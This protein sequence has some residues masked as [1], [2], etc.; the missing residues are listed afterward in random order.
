MKKQFHIKV[1]GTEELVIDLNDNE[2]VSVHIDNPPIKFQKE[3]LPLPT[4]R[5]DGLRWKDEQHFHLGWMEKNIEIGD[6]VRIKIVESN[7]QATLLNKEEEYISPEEKCSFCR[8]KKSEVEILI[9]KDF[10]ARICNECVDLA[11]TA[12]DEHRNAT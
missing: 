4:I 10:M 1:T 7:K 8:K 12:M 2:S 5:V 9:E 3:D 11:Q 6:E